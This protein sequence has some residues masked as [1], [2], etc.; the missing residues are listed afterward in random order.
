MRRAAVAMSL[1][2]LGV[3]ACS[4]PDRSN[5][6]ASGEPTLLT[7]PPTIRNGEAVNSAPTPPPSP[8]PVSASGPVETP[9]TSVHG[10]ETASSSATAVTSAPSVPGDSGAT[11]SAASSVPGAAAPPDTS[12]PTN[13][14][15]STPADAVDDPRVGASLPP[16]ETH[17][18]FE[19]EIDTSTADSLA[20][21]LQQEEDRQRAESPPEEPPLD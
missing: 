18:T 15:T 19:S 10:D 1:L 11:T 2:A 21:Y 16:G 5:Q 20:A 14:S 17:P 12:P 9:S 13:S 6:P 4:A 3:V 7:L 8:I